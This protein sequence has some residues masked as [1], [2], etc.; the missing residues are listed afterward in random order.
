M[1]RTPWIDGP[2]YLLGDDGSG[3]RDAFGA[4]VPDSQQFYQAVQGRENGI[5]FGVTLPNP[6]YRGGTSP[7]SAPSRTQPAPAANLPAPAPV[8]PQMQFTFDTIGQVIVRSI[9]HCRLAL[10]LIWVYGIDASGEYIDGSIVSSDAPTG[11]TA[12]ICD[13]VPSWVGAGIGIIGAAALANGIVVASVSGTSVVLSAPTIADIPAGTM[14]TFFSS[15]VAT[16]T[17]DAAPLVTFLE[18]ATGGVPSFVLPGTAVT[19]GS[20]APGATVV[21]VNG[22]HSMVGISAPTLADMPA[23]TQITFSRGAAAAT[24]AGALCAPIDP[25]EEGDI[26]A[27]LSGDTLISESAALS[28]LSASDQQQ[29]TDSLAG[30]RFYRGDEAQLPDPAIVSDK[31]AAVTNAFRGIRYVV[32]PSFPTSGL[33]GGAI[34]LSNLSVIYRRNNPIKP[35]NNITAVEFGAGA[36]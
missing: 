15:G 22:D 8:P 13:H 21:S 12:L 18:F 1:G 11:S 31:G 29:I 35:V 17:A 6:N 24:F 7:S 2:N 16:T 25:D 27:F 32:F 28:N 5:G 26:L 33:S 30:V 14:I 20:I 19:G 36:S 10:K 23:G 3:L 9:G 34:S 4:R